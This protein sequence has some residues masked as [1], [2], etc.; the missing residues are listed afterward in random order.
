MGVKI[1]S[2]MIHKRLTESIVGRTLYLMERYPNDERLFHDLETSA[3]DPVVQAFFERVSD[4]QTLIDEIAT[5][6]PDE[7]KDIIKDLDNLWPYKDT[8]IK[9]TGWSYIHQPETPPTREWIDERIVYS[10]G[11]WIEESSISLEDEEIASTYSIVHFYRMMD[12]DGSP[13][14]AISRLAD[15]QIEYPFDSVEAKRSRLEY[16]EP[17]LLDTF[18]EIV[19]N[20]NTEEE[21][22]MALRGI[23]AT[24][25]KD[26][27]G[28]L[29]DLSYYLDSILEFDKHV[30][31]IVKCLGSGYKED[32]GSSR[33]DP[34]NLP[35][36]PFV[37]K[38]VDVTFI[39][40]E[41][42]T[43]EK[44]IETYHPAINVLYY[45]PEGDS[46]SLVLPVRNIV[47]FESIRRRAYTP[48]TTSK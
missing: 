32:P 7:L 8:L 4:Y 34:I 33:F 36:T 1:I 3:I 38:V 9:M 23:E 6:S 35:T 21:A 11:F 20:H 14:L 12:T 25:K 16:H 18:D 47:E 26:N 31:Y 17:V 39:R 13:R 44:G 15:V 43:N 22:L 19:L 40:R 37:V 46:V 30:P 27:I 29:S 28:A 48:T 41:R 42:D 45:P 10:A 5:P 2:L 24:I